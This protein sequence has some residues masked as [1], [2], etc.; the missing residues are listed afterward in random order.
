MRSIYY[1]VLVGKQSLILSPVAGRTDLVASTEPACTSLQPTFLSE[2]GK[3]L[4][5]QLPHS[6]E[7]S[8]TVQ[9]AI[10]KHWTVRGPLWCES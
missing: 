9:S 4:G 6:L 1:P 8:N 5:L 7:T 3:K 10:V 2:L